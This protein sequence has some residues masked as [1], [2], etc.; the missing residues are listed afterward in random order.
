MT[1][2]AHD[3]VLAAA[4][5]GDDQALSQLVRTYHDRVHRFG[6]RVCRDGWDAEDAVQEAFAKLVRRPEVV[7]DPGALAWLLAVVRHACVRMLRPFARER[8]RLGTRVDD[9]ETLPSGAE[10]AQQALERWEVVQS[11]HAGIAA[12][13][14]ACPATRPAARSV[15]SSRR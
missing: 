11:V 14:R 13:W 7:K 1:I 9:T 5:R 12:L 8:R 3:E 15:W 10:D 2:L 4:A 6:L